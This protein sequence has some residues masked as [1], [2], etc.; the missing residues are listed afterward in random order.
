VSVAAVCPGSFDPV[1]LGHLDI[2]TR[3]AGRFDRLVVAVLENPRK[4][5]L[6]S[7]DERIALLEAEIAHLDNVEVATFQGLLVDFCRDRGIGLV[8]KGL[9]A[10]SD[11]EYELQMAQM[12]QRIGAVETLFLPT[13]AEHSYLSSSLV[14]EVARYGG[15]ISGTVTPAVER[16]L[17]EKLAS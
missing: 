4:Q 10:V 16:A 15:S 14:K 2:I 5:G 9:R 13:S 7:V 1:T 3:A 8:V 6:F 12:N 11:F 17:L